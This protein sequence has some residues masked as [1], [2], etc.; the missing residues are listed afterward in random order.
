MQ[1]ILKAVMKLNSR[2]PTIEGISNGEGNIIEDIHETHNTLTNFF[3]NKYQDTGSK[4]KF[5]DIVAPNII[6]NQETFDYIA[7]KINKKKGNGYDYIPLSILN[8]VNGRK[9]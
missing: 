8:N 4:N 7:S 5:A 9:F 1:D 6:L 3:R 2:P